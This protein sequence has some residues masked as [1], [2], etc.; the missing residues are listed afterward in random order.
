MNISLT[1]SLKEKKNIK[2]PSLFG[3]ED[4]VDIDKS[5]EMMDTERN[6]H[7]YLTPISLLLDVSAFSSVH[8]LYIYHIIYLLKVHLKTATQYI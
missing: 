7:N 2:T 4:E 1:N 8:K 6:F 3:K 5:F